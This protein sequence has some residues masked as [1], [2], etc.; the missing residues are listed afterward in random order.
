M[1][2]RTSGI[3]FVRAYLPALLFLI[4]GMSCNRPHPVPQNKEAFIGLWHSHSGFKMEI[5]ASGTANLAQIDN[6][7]DPESSKLD[8]GVTPEFAKDM[9]V[10]FGGDTLLII[11]KPQVRGREYRIDR[12]P[13]MDGDTCKMILN[14]VL[15]IR[16]K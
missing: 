7:M 11:V 6:P 5:K 12:N 9:L 15:L 16:Q 8:I 14:G 10:K 2:N 13:Y 3:F 1:K 4:A